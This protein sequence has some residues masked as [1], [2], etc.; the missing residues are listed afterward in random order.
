MS[1]PPY[2]DSR[3]QEVIE[4][5]RHAGLDLDEHQQLVLR[6]SLGVREDGLWAAFE[7]GVNEPRQNGKGG[8]LEARELGGLFLFG[9]R[10]SIH[11]AHQFDTSMEA[12]LRLLALVE[13]TPDL[14]RQVK[15]VTRS[16]GEEGITL[17]NGQRIRFR[18]R[19][20]GG[21]RGFSCD[22]L[23]LDEAMFMPEFTHGALL[24]TLSARPNP[25]VWYTGSAVDQ[26]VH[27]NG[28]VF[29]RVRER[30]LA[31]GDKSLAYFEWS[32]PVDHPSEVT[33]D[34]A[35]SPAMW[36]MANP[37]LGIRISAEHI[38]HEL[39]S[40]DARTFA[41]ERLGAGDYPRT[42]GEI[43]G[44]ISLE[45]W[46]ALAD[47]K[48]KLLD[49]VCI[50]YDISPDRRAS[51]VAAGYNAARRLHVEVIANRSGTQWVPAKLLE[52]QER[53]DPLVVVGDGY[54]PAASLKTTIEEA[55]V[56]IE[57]STA[58]E[59]AQA[60]GL[61]LDAVTQGTLVHL[62]SDE[63]RSAIRGA[64]TRPLGDAW[65]WSRK[66]S[67]TD[68]SPLVAATLAVWAV[69]ERPDLDEDPVIW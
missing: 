13:N 35:E 22:D 60:C 43:A 57:Q 5:A 16:H 39:R 67:N 46:D 56:A 32:I 45:Q 24:P 61:L 29:T 52:L 1:V 8:I 53:H 18:T 14:D 38:E 63:L 3:G 55:G 23:Y 68:I 62:G 31:G 37:A 59:H 51:I 41:V 44:A 25:Q 12:F 19:T 54:G 40:M 4:L 7:V 10:L 2:D 64:A 66:N 20:R 69:L 34:V 30:G 11:S 9:S 42:D 17:M 33:D 48:S 47:D 50:A 58:N 27:E 65:A 6:E 26:E 15:K 36:R 28:V 21:G 49:P